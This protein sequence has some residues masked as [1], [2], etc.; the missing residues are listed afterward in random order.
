MSESG[1]LAQARAYLLVLNFCYKYVSKKITCTSRHS[2]W[3]CSSENK[4]FYVMCKKTK[5]CVK[6]VVYV[7]FFYTSHKNIKFSQNL[8]CTHRIS[9]SKREF[10]IQSF[11][12]F[13]IFFSCFHICLANVSF[14]IFSNATTN[15]I[16]WVAHLMVFPT[17]IFFIK[18]KISWKKSIFAW[19]SS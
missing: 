9:R 1:V 5:F 3:N 6:K 17:Q 10:F 8:M 19:N 11:W 15:R 7:N 13:K 16:K 12:H 4:H 14:K 2:M 18:C